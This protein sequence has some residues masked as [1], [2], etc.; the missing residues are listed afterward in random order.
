M[1]HHLGK[2]ISQIE[3]QRKNIKIEDGMNKEDRGGT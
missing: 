1:I 3:R 2:G